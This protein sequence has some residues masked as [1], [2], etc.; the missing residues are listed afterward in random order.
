M[1]AFG[2]FFSGGAGGLKNAK[3][4]AASALRVP[5]FPMPAGV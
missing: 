5:G 1:G 4:P 3:R 2:D